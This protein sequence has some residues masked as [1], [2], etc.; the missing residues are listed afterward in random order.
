M[1]LYI[2]KGLGKQFW[3]GLVF[4]A[5]L[6][7]SW[8]FHMTSVSS[9]GAV[10]SVSHVNRR[11]QSYSENADWLWQ[12]SPVN[13]PVVWILVTLSRI[14]KRNNNKT[15]EEKANLAFQQNDLTESLMLISCHEGWYDGKQCGFTSWWCDRQHIFLFS[16]EQLQNSKNKYKLLKPWRVKL[17]LKT[18]VSIGFDIYCSQC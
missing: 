2:F 8:N 13:Q 12:G 9:L 6:L 17:I 1:C 10:W 18:C 7:L 16:V 4:C 14:L 5:S 15:A 11:C 3:N